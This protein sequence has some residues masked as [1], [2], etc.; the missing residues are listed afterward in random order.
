MAS[1]SKARP[2]RYA[3][4]GTAIEA[5]KAAPGL[6]LVATPIGNLGDITLRALELLAGADVIACEDT[7]VTR[8]LTERYGIDD[9]AHALPRTQRRRGAAEAARPPRRWASGRAGIGRRHA[10]DLRPRLQAGASGLR[11]RSRGDRAAGRVR[12]LGCIV[13][14]GP[15]DRPFLLRRFSAAQTSS[16]AK[17]RCRA[18]KYSGDTWCCS[19]A[20]RALLRCSPT[21]PPRSDRARPQSAAS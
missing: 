14:R 13:D 12:G 17:T 9:A 8:K 4:F 18:R 20:D 2:R 3:P 10:V 16:T 21:L 7:R 1:E 11:G 15:A 6:Y 5:A 19:R